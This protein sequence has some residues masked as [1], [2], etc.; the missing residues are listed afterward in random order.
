MTVKGMMFNGVEITMEE[1]TKKM[2]ELKVLQ[3]LQKEAK[4]AGLVGAKAVAK[5]QEKS[6]NFNLILA[7]FAPV[8]N[9][10]RSIITALFEEFVG[11]DSVS[12]DCDKEYH[13]IVRSKAVVKAKQEARKAKLLKAKAEKES[14]EAMIEEAEIEAEIE[15]ETKAERKKLDGTITEV[16]EYNEEGEKETEAV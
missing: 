3:S 9:A 11:Q 8:I 15:K 1:L 12:F 16:E 4:K 7:Q 10:N 6:A 13:V 5:K 2:T 14:M